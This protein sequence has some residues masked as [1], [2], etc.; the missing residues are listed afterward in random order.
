VKPLA[1]YLLA[2]CFLTAPVAVAEG[3]LLA[4]RELKYLASVYL[5]S[6]LLLPQGLLR[7]KKFQGPVSQVWGAFAAFQLFRALCFTGRIWGVSFLK[8]FSGGGAKE[9]RKKAS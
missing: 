3:V 9:A 6:T 4:G 1:P 7:I 8:K 2:G 5:I